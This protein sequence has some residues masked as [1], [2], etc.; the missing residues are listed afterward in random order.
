MNRTFSR[1]LVA[2]AALALLIGL[3]VAVEQLE[4]T[5]VVCIG[6]LLVQT[7]GVT[8]NGVTVRS[9]GTSFSFDGDLSLVTVEAVVDMNA[10]SGSA[11]CIAVSPR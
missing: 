10:S 1:V 3:V 5:K 11:R 6:D 9:D 8:V 2:A 4:P 7:I